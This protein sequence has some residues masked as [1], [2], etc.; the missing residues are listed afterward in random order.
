MQGA[1]A[2]EAPASVTMVAPFLLATG[3]LQSTEVLEA[4]A[5]QIVA[6]AREYFEGTLK[7]KRA[8]ELV[9][10]MELTS[11]FDQIAAAGSSLTAA[12]TGKLAAFNFSKKPEYA[13]LL[14]KRK[15]ELPKYVALAK[16]IKPREQRS[17]AKGKGTCDLFACHAL[18]QHSDC[19]PPI[20]PPLPWIL[21]CGPNDPVAAAAG[22]DMRAGESAVTTIAAATAIAT[23]G[24]T[25]TA[26][27]RASKAMDLRLR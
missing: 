12:D 9:S 14:P 21:C 20:L 23:P 15:G 1:G 18:P 4:R 3:D 7:V 11:M 17:D 10:W 19:P 27:Q 22:E 13:A 16:K 25:T 5:Q 2:G 8:E 6:G 24:G 26:I